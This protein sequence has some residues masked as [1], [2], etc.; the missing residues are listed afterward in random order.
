M[1]PNGSPGSDT[2]SDPA[3]RMTCSAVIATAPEAVS[4][5]QLLASVKVAQPS[6]TRTFACARRPATPPES[7]STMPSFH[8]TVRAR[9]SRGGWSS[10][11]PSVVAAGDVGKPVGGVD[12]RL[13]RDTAANEAGAA[14]ALRLRPAPCRGQAGRR[15]SRRHSRPA[16]RRRRAREVARFPAWLSLTTERHPRESGGRGRATELPTPGFPLSR[17]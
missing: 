10:V 4:T 15:G 1:P 13:R 14:E 17:E 16:R 8:A 7:R 12:Q 5:V 2:G 3:A 6:T 11:M 9:S